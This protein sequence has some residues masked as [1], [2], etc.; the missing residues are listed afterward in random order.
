LNARQA[1]CLDFLSEY[2][3][4]IEHIKGKENKIAD[5]LSRKINAISSSNIQSD[6]KQKITSTTENDENIQKIQGKMSE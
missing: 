4:E 6:L 2:D 1:R 5:A 3:F